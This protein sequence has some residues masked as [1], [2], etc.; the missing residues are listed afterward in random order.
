MFSPYLEKVIRGENLKFEEMEEAM[1]MIMK[2][3][4]S[5]CQLSGF[6]VALHMKGETVEEIT[7]SATVMRRRATLI[8]VENEKLMDTCGTG[9]DAKGTFNIST[10]VAFVLAA[11]DIPVAKHGNRSVSSKSGSADVLESL[12]I[13]ISLPPALVKRCLE[14]I[15]IAF[16]FAQDFHKA[17]RYAAVPRK[18]LGVKTIFNIL[19]PLTNPANVKYQLTGVYDPDLVYPIAEVLKNLGVRRAM[20]VHGAGGID[21]LSLAGKNEIAFLHDGEIERLELSPQDVGMRC[22][23][24]EDIHGGSA[25]ENKKI[26]LDIF[27]GAMGP[28]RDVVVLN[29]A[30]GLYIANKVSSLEE[31][32]TYAQEIIDSKKALQKVNE[33]IRLTNLLTLEK[34]VPEELSF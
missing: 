16:L 19:G 33:M 9:G 10:A 25:Q 17:T 26:I 22:F 34:N 30:A 32:I 20:V 11:A 6:L 7:A 8:D 31:G 13:D 5:H 1:E 2:G 21:E 18:E 12:G 27:H 4:V 15:G 24:L 14:E 29:S 28:K 23:D 3:E